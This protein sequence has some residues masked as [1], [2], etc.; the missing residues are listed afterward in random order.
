MK[1]NRILS[2]RVDRIF[3]S[4]I[5]KI[6]QEVKKRK[7]INFVSGLPDPRYMPMDILYELMCETYEEHGREILMY[8]GAYGLEVLRE[9]IKRF[10]ERHGVNTRSKEVIITCGAQHAVSSIARAVLDDNDVYAVENPTFME[11]FLA[12]KYY[13]DNYLPIDVSPEGLD[14]VALRRA[15]SEEIKLLYVVP[16]G[17]NPTGI[18]Y[19]DD[20]RREIA[21]ISNEMG[22]LIVEDDPYG[23]IVE[24][25]VKAISNIAE[26]AIYVGSFSKILAPGLRVGFMLIPKE[27]FEKIGMTMQLDFATHP[28]SMF[29]VYEALRRGIVE[30][31]LENLRKVYRRKTRIALSTIEETM[32]KGVEW[33]KPEISFHIMLFLNGTNAEKLLERSLKKGVAFVPG[34]MFYIKNPREDS[35]RISFSQPREEEIEKGIGIIAETIR[36]IS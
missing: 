5:E 21:E 33:T 12:M 3:W 11:T 26:N 7:V 34:K 17:Q 31:V 6:S 10:L 25:K 9:E 15:S 19:S 30:S 16:R 8:P 35:I 2:K 28:L 22:F 32:P 14:I 20:V 18:S 36:E 23:I 1:K 4:S 24:R 29:V 13:S 27:F